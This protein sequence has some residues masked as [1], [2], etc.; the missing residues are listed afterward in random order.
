VG[1]VWV[2]WVEC[3]WSVSREVNWGEWRVNWERG[4]GARDEGKGAGGEG[5]TL[6]VTGL[7]VP[8]ILMVAVSPNGYFE[9]V[10]ILPPPPTE[11]GRV[12]EAGTSE[13]TTIASPAS[14]VSLP[15]LAAAAASI[16]NAAMANLGQP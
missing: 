16:T 13:A 10:S 2:E 9:S 6:T 14:L 1:G 5:G 11:A 12:A 7:V 3:G 15:A 8:L 4:G